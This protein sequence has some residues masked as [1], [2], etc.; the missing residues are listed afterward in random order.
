MQN[1][2]FNFKAAKEQIDLVYYIV[3]LGFQYS[4]QN[5]HDYWF[6]SPLHEEH[7][8]SFKVDRRRQ[9]WYDH[10]TGQG[11]DLIDFIKAFHRCDFKE[12]LTKLQEYLGLNPS[13]MEA[14]NKQNI[15]QDNFEN[16]DKHIHI[17][18][19]RSVQKYYLRQYIQSRHISISIAEKFLKE[20]DYSLKE[21]NYTALGFANNDGGYELRNKYFKGSSMP[22]APTIISLTE[23]KNDISQQSLSVFEGFFSILSFLELLEKDKHFTE[24][25]DSILVLNSLSFLNKSQ[26]LIL[27]FGQID[28]Y[29]DGDT[30]GKKAT[31]HALSWSE[32]I[33][34][35]SHLYES[36]KDLNTYLV[37]QDLQCKEQEEPKISYG[38]RR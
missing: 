37:P 10:G 19:E 22:K 3:S 20:V 11:G 34:D 16:A 17:I 14:K 7:T 30:A 8:A 25:P 18:A 2:Q 38:L 13:T 5:H 29:L 28:M 15:E 33:S 24:K 4:K 23:G 32:K 35:C 1:E 31:K 21:R 27:S 9:I 6:K 26:D 12:S 36:F